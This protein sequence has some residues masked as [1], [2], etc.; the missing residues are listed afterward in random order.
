MDDPSTI[1]AMCGDYRASFHL[2]RRTTPRTATPAAASPAPLLLVTGEEETQL[3]DAPA[4]W[5]AWADD[6][7]AVTVPGGH[8]VPEE[9]PDALYAALAAFLSPPPSGSARA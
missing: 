9:A 5:R 4:I 6:V 1:A 7:T 8:F 3:A 2:D